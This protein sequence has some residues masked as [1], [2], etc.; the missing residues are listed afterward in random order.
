M[1]KH[2][3]QPITGVHL[4]E[5]GQGV[6]FVLCSLVGWLFGE[7]HRGRRRGRG[8]EARERADATNKSILPKQIFMKLLHM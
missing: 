5:K 1:C 3:T 8:S 6:T 4:G 7:F 2:Y